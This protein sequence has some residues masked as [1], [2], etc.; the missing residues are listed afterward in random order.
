MR[1]PVSSLPLFLRVRATGAAVMLPSFARLVF[2]SVTIS[3]PIAVGSSLCRR[4]AG[5]Q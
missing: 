1:T 2:P 5:E 3:L 4:S